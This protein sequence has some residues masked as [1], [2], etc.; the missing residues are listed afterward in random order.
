MPLAI[1]KVLVHVSVIVQLEWQKCGVTQL[2]NEIV[3]GVLFHVD[4]N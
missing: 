1:I 3:V 2:D 4:M